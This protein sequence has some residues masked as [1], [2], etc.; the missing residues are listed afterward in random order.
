MHLGLAEA[1]DRFT[2]GRDADA[3]Q[4]IAEAHAALRVRGRGRGGAIPV[5]FRGGSRGDRR[6]VAR[7]RSGCSWS[8]ASTTSAPSILRCGC[9]SWFVLSFGLIV[10]ACDP[11]VRTV[12]TTAGREL[13]T[14]AGGFARFLT[15]DSSESRFD[16]AAHL[17]WYPRYLAWAVALGVA[18]VGPIAT[19]PRGSRS[20]RSRGSTGTAS[21]RST[22]PRCRRRSTRSSA[23]RN[24]GVRRVTGVVGSRRLVRRRRFLRR[25]GWWRR[26]RRFVV[27]TPEPK[28]VPTWPS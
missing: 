19:R 23:P 17:D 11:G 24:D 22:R 27:G 12:R 15:T 13:W 5:R 20:P 8:P 9:W 14:R 3:G 25:V 2:V 6:R 7:A 1:G 18:T 4:E 26:G 28:E 10:M 16:A 21:R